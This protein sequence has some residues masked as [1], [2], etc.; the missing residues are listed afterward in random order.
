MGIIKKEGMPTEFTHPHSSAW[1][2]LFPVKGGVGGV[3]A[4]AKAVISGSRSQKIE[5]RDP[6]LTR[7]P[8]AYR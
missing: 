6:P 5:P 1:D 3:F 4:T 2:R 8:Q 7:A